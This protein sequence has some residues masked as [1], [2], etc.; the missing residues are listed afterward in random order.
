MF[1]TI[2]D[3]EKS[4]PVIKDFSQ[5]QKQKALEVFN[6]LHEQNPE[7]DQKLA[8]ARAIEQTNFAETATGLVYMLSGNTSTIEILRV[9]TVFDRG[10]KVTPEMLDDYVSNFNAGVYGTEVQVNLSHNRDGEAA[11]WVRRLIREGEKLFAEVE[12]T[13]L[14]KDKISTKQYQFTSA[15]LALSYPHFQT[16]AKVK[17]VL[18]GVALTNIPAVKGLAPVQLSEEVQL[19]INNSQSM[20]ALKA[21]YEK[22]AAKETISEDEMTSFKKKA[23]EVG[24]DE[25]TGM[26]KKLSGKVKKLSEEAPAPAKTEEGTVKLSEFQAEQDKNIKLQEKVDRM[27]L[28]EVVSTTLMLSDK[29][30]K[31]GF[32]PAAKEEVVNFMLKLSED[33]RKAFVELMGKVQKVDLSVNGA[34]GAPKKEFTE[35]AVVELAQKKMNEAQAAGKTLNVAD[36]Q[37]AAM[38]EL[39]QK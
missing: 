16:G 34:T 25:A 33:Q 21:L 2:E 38:F 37:K 11:G 27:E 3:F 22:L 17:N 19:F 8:I 5:E 7:I 32:A 30:D 1:K 39:S 23:D 9:G 18:I 6:R 14:G 12:W 29:S 13:P 35:D 24:G 20:D 31:A 28:N 10:F 36:A 4:A 26:A 15:E